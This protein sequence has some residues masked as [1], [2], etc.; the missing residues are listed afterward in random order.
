MAGNGA[1]RDPVSELW[2]RAAPGILQRAYEQR[3][4]WYATRITDPLP[5]HLLY[6]RRLGIDVTGP[7]NAA[8]ISGRHINYRTRWNRSFVRCLHYHNDDRHGGPGGP[9]EIQV[10]APKPASPGV[11]AGWSVRLRIRRG[12]EGRAYRAVQR[13]AY[14]DR[15]WL[16][17]GEPGGRFSDKEGRDW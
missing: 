3:G 17:D 8:T 10:G 2:D 12:G 6:F 5:A 1:T 15:I 13:K 14:G 11:P 16:E 4:G 9:L 7:D